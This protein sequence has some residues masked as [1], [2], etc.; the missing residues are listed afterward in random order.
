[1]TITPDFPHDRFDRKSAA[2]AWRD[3][4]TTK[5][6]DVLAAA[7]LILVFGASGA[8]LAGGLW[9][10]LQQV[11]WSALNGIIALQLARQAVALA[12]IVLLMTFLVL[13]NPAKAK[14][15][16]LMPRLA[17]FAGTYLGVL[18]VWLPQQPIG[19]A[20]SLAS[21][22][23]MLGGTAF[24]AY[25][26][27][28]L[29]RSFSIMAEGRKLVADGPYARIRHPLYLG[30]ALSFFGLTLQYLSPLALTIFAVQI[31]FQLVRMKNEEGVLSD[32]FPEYESYKR[33]TAR[34]V[35]GLY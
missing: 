19:V 13:R 8:H 6:Y 12:F 20:L 26:I 9:A 29:G 11:D 5:L 28:H 27:S 18:L 15:K 7:P 33:R 35:P 1:M 25:S 34:L 30:E 4:E 2:A 16:G 17:A 10:N 23:L 24:S 31:G 21:L 32:L 3:F 14:A 22:L